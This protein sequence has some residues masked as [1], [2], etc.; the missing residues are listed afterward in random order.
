MELWTPPHDSPHL[1]EWWRP[2][3]L[4]SQR[5]RVRQIP[6]PIHVDEFRLAGRVV[7][8]GR[9]D[10]WIYEHHAHGGALCVDATGA[11]YRFIPTPRARG[12]GQF[13]PC[14]I[15]SAVWRAGLPEVVEPVWYEEARRH[16]GD[17]VVDS[18]DD[19]E[20]DVSGLRKA[21]GGTAP[22]I[23]RGHLHLVPST[24]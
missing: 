23:S 6:W 4:A 2:L 21:S 17:E 7:R 20:A 5:A 11:T 10:I 12:V 3:M 1:L 9:P 18:G 13:R 8:N 19:L 15:R 14:D 24:E 16:W 22:V